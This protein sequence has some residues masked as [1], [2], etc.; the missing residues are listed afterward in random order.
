MAAV[1]ASTTEHSTIR[2]PSVV[3]ENGALDRPREAPGWIVLT[4]Y[5]HIQRAR[6][7]ST[8]SVVNAIR[9]GSVKISWPIPAMEG[10]DAPSPAAA[11]P[12]PVTT[13][14]SSSSHGTKAPSRPARPD[15]PTA[16]RTLTSAHDDVTSAPAPAPTPTP[17]LTPT[18]TPTPMSVPVSAS[19]TVGR[20]GTGRRPPPEE[21]T[22]SAWGVGARSLPVRPAPVAGLSM[23]T[24]DRPKRKGNSVRTILRRILRRSTVK[25]TP[26]PSERVAAVQVER[27]GHH[28]RSVS[29]VPGGGRMKLAGR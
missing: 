3:R 27:S 22:Y 13:M 17:M 21:T 20:P 6:D 2:R 18:P 12:P 26:P 29:T 24:T 10:A 19:T 16:T 23:T 11:I 28:H 1:S 9:R 25:G 7:P 14:A 4:V 5:H 8:T 15:S